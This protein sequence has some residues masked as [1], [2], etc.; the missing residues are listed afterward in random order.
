MLWAAN[1]SVTVYWKH[2]AG[3]LLSAVAA[4]EKKTPSMPYN[5]VTQHAPWRAIIVFP[6]FMNQGDFVASFGER[7][8]PKLRRKGPQ[9]RKPPDHRRY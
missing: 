4:T 9:D 8:T 1:E 7:E 2:H 6:S 3:R 5:D